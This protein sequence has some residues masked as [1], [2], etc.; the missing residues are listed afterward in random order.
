MH[1][2]GHGRYQ[3]NIGLVAIWLRSLNQPR[4]TKCPGFATMKMGIE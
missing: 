2:L 1:T 4:V 3:N